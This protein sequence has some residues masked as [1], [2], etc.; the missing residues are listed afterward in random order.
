MYSHNGFSINIRPEGAVHTVQPVTRSGHTYYPLSNNTNYSVILRNDRA[1]RC[2]VELFIDD[3]KMG[4]WRID[5]LSK[6]EIN[7][8]SSVNRKFLFVEESS[9]KA[10][11]GGVGPGSSSNGLITAKFYPEMYRGRV[12][13][14]IDDDFTSAIPHVRGLSFNAPSR[15]GTGC[16]GAQCFRASLGSRGSVMNENM[17][18]QNSSLGHNIV[19]DTHYMRSG[20]TVLQGESLQ[21]FNKL[22]PI[23]D[24]DRENITT[25]SVRL[26]VD[27]YDNRVYPLTTQPSHVIPR[28]PRV[29]HLPRS[30]PF[31]PNDP[32][33]T[34]FEPIDQHVYPIDY[35]EP[36][37]EGGG[38][39]CHHGGC[40]QGGWYN[41]QR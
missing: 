28:P 41:G 23:R 40:R 31:R 36:Q 12:S 34:T 19:N 26:V 17:S 5:A 25:V 20:A 7:R 6:I 3:H 37:F 14:V 8:P 30:D 4:K 13:E 22:A 39:I 1:S 38:P 21:R 35:R 32:L 11:M 18:Y 27:G 24:L 29:D 2:D 33:F 15:D 9:S 10:F 16:Y